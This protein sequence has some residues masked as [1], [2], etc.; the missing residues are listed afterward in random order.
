M[1]GEPASVLAGRRQLDR[2]AAPRV[3]RFDERSRL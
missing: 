2:R 3:G 1:A